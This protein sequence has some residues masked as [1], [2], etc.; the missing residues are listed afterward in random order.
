MKCT[1]QYAIFI[2]HKIMICITKTCHCS[3]FWDIH[4]QTKGSV[5]VVE[6]NHF[7]DKRIL[8][9]LM[10]WATIY[11]VEAYRL[12]S[13]STLPQ[14]RQ[15]VLILL[16]K[17]HIKRSQEECRLLNRT[18]TQCCFRIQCYDFGNIQEHIMPCFLFWSSVCQV[19]WLLG[20]AYI[21]THRKD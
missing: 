15:K 1:A 19:G 3:H 20:D 11:T 4:Q 14:S 2:V 18:A 9:A 10:Q 7:R 17:E 5:K 12:W 21:F 13:L 8:S 6:M 16:C